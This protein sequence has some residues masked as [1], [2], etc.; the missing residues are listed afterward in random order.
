MAEKNYT[1]HK[2]FDH[3]KEIDWQENN[4]AIV[5]VNGKKI[6]LTHFNDTVFAF[7]FKCPHAGGI[8]ADGYVDALGNVVCPIHRY[9]YSLQSG[10]NIS[11][12]GYFLKHWPVELRDDGVYVGFEKEGGLFGCLK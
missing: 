12:E 4:M 5:E 8:L 7:A 10:H 6:S 3:I 11:G 9:K 2:I 1:W